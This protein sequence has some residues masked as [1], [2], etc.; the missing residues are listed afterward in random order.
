MHTSVDGLKGVQGFAQQVRHLSRDSRDRLKPVM[1]L[2]VGILP[3]KQLEHM[4]LAGCSGHPI[5]LLQQRNKLEVTMLVHL[6]ES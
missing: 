3:E 6:N 5:C 1:L 2:T 4:Q